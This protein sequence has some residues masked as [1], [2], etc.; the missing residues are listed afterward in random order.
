MSESE[1]VFR[2][3][4]AIGFARV[5]NS[6]EF[7]LGPET[8]AGLP[9]AE[10]DPATGGLP[11][12]PGTESQTITSSDLRDRNGAFKRQAARFRVYEYPRVQGE[13]TYPNGGGR[14]IGIG[15][16]VDGKKVVDVV[17]TVHVANKKANTYVLD[18]N[19]PTAGLAA[20]EDGQLPPL[21]N[22][23]EGP[24]SDNA[25]RL[26]KLTI[27]PGPRAIGGAGA[28]PVRVDR[29]TVATYGEG[30]EIRRLP[31]YPKSFPQD[32]FAELFCPTGDVDT[33]GELRT[34]ER[35]RLLVV[36]AYGRACAWYKDGKP[37]PLDQDVNN[38]GWFDDTADGPVNAALVFDDG[39]VA[40]VAGAWV[41]STDPGYAPQI[42]NAV[43]LWDD[44]YDT[45]IRKLRLQP[46]IF[47]RRFRDDYA[48][49]FGGFVDGPLGGDQGGE[50]G[51]LGGDRGGKHSRFDG[52]VW[53]MFRSAYLQR[54]ATNLPDIAVRA[55]E[56]VDKISAGDDPAETILGGLAFIRDPNDEDADFTGAPFMPLSLG[57]SNKPF[58]SLTL[59][60][61]FFLTQ[62]NE[63]RYRK[64]GGPRL[65]PGEYLD[66]A[67]L[68]AGLGG[69]FGPGID[70]TFVVRQPGLWTPDWC[71]SGGGPF[72]I[73]AKR[74]DYA[75]AQASQPFLGQGWVPLHTPPGEGVEP[76]DTSKLMAIPWHTD[77]NSCAT[78]PTSPELPPESG[79]TT[80]YWSW[81][82]QRPVVV[83]PVGEL[84]GG[85]LGPQ[86]YSLRGPGT[87]SPNPA[88]QGRYQERL[89]FIEN[90]PKVGVVI[91]G[92]AIDGVE[93][94]PEYYL[95]VAS[96]LDET[97]VE[98]W[99]INALPG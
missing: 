88:D 51:P 28:G 56:A 73:D 8:M 69:R 60:Q 58:L 98:P 16:T 64:E 59:T 7:Y 26:R 78:H 75:S 23:A 39:S 35:G 5:G 74:L 81:P 67:V 31:S 91:Q 84:R 83:Y 97:E 57:D 94:D 71:R 86:R 44:I 18:E 43:T 80:L 33:L 15:S 32:S 2:I 9:L 50:H 38:D 48:P 34:D 45:W 20:Y 77:Y 10:G 30:A 19:Y 52:Q 24:D 12:R 63:K 41:V 61:Y 93:V 27:D 85:K 11:I 66:K 37:S 29:A 6:E 89:R 62:W 92:T 4:P 87:Q 21:R 68:F 25:A 17:W 55:H 46:E 49:F 90:W 99:P 42:V 22:L 13:E 79:G 96:Q 70:M 47:D 65:G 76:G 40:E 82:A 54:W 53:P 95:E 3:H 1:H 36:G 72:R 14:E